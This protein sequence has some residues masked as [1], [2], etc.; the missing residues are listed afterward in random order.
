[1][2]QPVKIPLPLIFDDP[3]GNVKSIYPIKSW[4]TLTILFILAFSIIFFIKAPFK[5]TDIEL[6]LIFSAIIAGMV[7]FVISIFCLIYF[8]FLRKCVIIDRN[9]LT[10]PSIN[11]V[12]KAKK[13]LA[14]DSIKKI[15][16]EKNVRKFGDR[17]LKPYD[18]VGTFFKVVILDEN[19]F[20]HDVTPEI[21]SNDG[22][23]PKAW[24]SF[25]AKLS[26]SIGLPIE[27]EIQT[28]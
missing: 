27:N 20:K 11:K 14:K 2:I 13:V 18:V 9:N 8:V 26:K 3:W 12:S 6:Y 1:M 4:F 24:N 21:Y 17:N 22:N 15:V 23:Y 10:F 16:V 5:S 19:N 25:L 28:K 7:F